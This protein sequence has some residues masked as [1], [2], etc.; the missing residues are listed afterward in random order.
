MVRYVKGAPQQTPL[1]P[2]GY[3]V[4]LDTL[5]FEIS[6]EEAERGAAAGWMVNC[7]LTLSPE[8]RGARL[9]RTVEPH[10]DEA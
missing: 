6:S 5:A 10:F 9:G 2:A 8:F 7:G 3:E 1:G 4:V